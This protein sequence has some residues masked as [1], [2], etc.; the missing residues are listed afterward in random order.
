MFHLDDESEPV[1]PPLPPDPRS[2]LQTIIDRLLA[3]SADTG[4]VTLDAIGEALG[5]RPTS[6]DEVGRI[7]EAIENAGRTVVEPPHDGPR[8]DFDEGRATLG[9]LSP[10]WA[11]YLEGSQGFSARS[12]PPKP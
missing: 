10:P 2:D 3:D 5:T 9:I 12:E 4:Q 8:P 6:A 1:S 7:L 11:P